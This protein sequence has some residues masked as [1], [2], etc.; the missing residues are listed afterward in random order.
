MEDVFSVG[1]CDVGFENDAYC[2]SRCVGGGDWTVV[3][4]SDKG[5]LQNIEASDSHEGDEVVSAHV[6]EDGSAGGRDGVAN[7]M[8]DGR[9]K[10]G[11]RLPEMKKSEP[12][13]GA[14]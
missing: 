3:V 1:G 14:S 13:L 4:I 12:Q 11:T 8:V 5:T 2:N 7:W 9:W 6:K 10:V